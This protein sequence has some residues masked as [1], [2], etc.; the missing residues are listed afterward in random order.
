[1]WAT[2]FYTVTG[3]RQLKQALRIPALVIEPIEKLCPRVDYGE[4]IGHIL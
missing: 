1:M 3:P 2:V 4:T